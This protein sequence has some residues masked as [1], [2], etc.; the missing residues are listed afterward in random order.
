LIDIITGNRAHVK[1]L[2]VSVYT[3][4]VKEVIIWS[5]RANEILQFTVHTY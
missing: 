2:Q 5:R 3:G 1:L 4:H